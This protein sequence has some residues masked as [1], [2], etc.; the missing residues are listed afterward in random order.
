M[1]QVR[2]AVSVPLQSLNLMT[3]TKIVRDGNHSRFANVAIVLF[4]NFH[5]PD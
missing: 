4:N 2:G 1:E 5:F 3:R